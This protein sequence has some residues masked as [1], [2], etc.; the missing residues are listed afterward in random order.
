MDSPT[1]FS[2]A[3][4]T[5]AKVN[6]MFLLPSFT[7][8][9][10]ERTSLNLLSEINKNLFSICL[11][12]SRSVYKY[13]E[14][15]NLDRFISIEDLEIDVWFSSYTKLKN[16]IK[17]VAGILKSQRPELAFGMMHYPSSLLVF[18]KKFYNL[19]TKIIVSPRG[20]SK[21]YLWYFEKTL[22]RKLILKGV[23]TFFLRYADGIV[24]A[25][26]G[27]KEECIRHFSAAPNIIE[28]IPNSVNTEEVMKKALEDVNIDLPSGTF[29]LS[30]VSRLERE[31]NLPL[32]LKALSDVIRGEK[33]ALLLIGE[34]SE[35]ESLES[36]SHKLGINRHIIFAGY[37][38]NPYKFIKKSDI[39][40]HTCLF[41]GFANVIIEAMACGVPV[42]ATDC[43]YGPRDIII[44]G[45]SGLLVN[46]NDRKAL[47]NAIITLMH[48]GRLRQNIAQKGL[49]RS[50]NFTIKAMAKGYE[51]F[52]K[53]IAR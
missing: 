38:L 36:L 49:L 15:L 53:K 28:V 23:F 33:A 50:N 17:K 34:G 1:S 51:N 29:L 22:K 8:G 5:G 18:A 14:H 32:L 12:T 13:F 7:F 27:M 30:A 39:F 37:Q 40:I 24:V 48:D 16:D 45:E 26:R 42:I 4:I 6:V 47:T 9:G 10:A 25:S 46:M 31:K 43:P 44:N 19:K 2:N 41:E 3:N 11:V 20:P 52:F 35:R 21:E